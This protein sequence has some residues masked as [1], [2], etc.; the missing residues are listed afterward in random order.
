[1]ENKI[2]TKIT[3]AMNNLD[4]AADNFGVK[5]AT[6]ITLI[7][8]DL[9]DIRNMAQQLFRENAELKAKIE[10]NGKATEADEKEVP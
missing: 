2:M 3:S 8:Q 9:V 10:E 4:S 1:M 6:Y 5:R 7:A